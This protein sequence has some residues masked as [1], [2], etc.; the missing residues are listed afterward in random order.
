MTERITAGW[1]TKRSAHT[2]S[3]RLKAE[4]YALD[5]AVSMEKKG[6]AKAVEGAYDLVVLD[7]MLPKKT[8]NDV[9]PGH[10]QG[11]NC[12]TDHQC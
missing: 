3:D 10:P 5:T 7:V 1:K 2:L 8:W 11:G 12:N 9:C 4:G 6:C